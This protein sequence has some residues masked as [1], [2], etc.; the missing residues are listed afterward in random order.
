[1]KRL[2]FFCAVAATL[3]LLQ[4]CS[5]DQ[6]TSDSSATLYAAMQ[7]NP[8]LATQ[9]LPI[10]HLDSMD[11]WQPQAVSAVAYAATVK[12][13]AT[14]GPLTISVADLES[15]LLGAFLKPPAL[16][17][18]MTDAYLTDRVDEQGTLLCR[19]YYPK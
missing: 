4:A 18:V 8:S 12:T 16:R 15:D 13:A 9:I 7:D 1:M 17:V 10:S 6:T 19:Q 2:L 3:G 14:D 11:N 5:S